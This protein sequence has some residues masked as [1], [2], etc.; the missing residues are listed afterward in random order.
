MSFE[1]RD[2]VEYVK[3]SDIASYSKTRISIDK[4]NKNNYINREIT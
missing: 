2:G 4:L 1:I 3:L